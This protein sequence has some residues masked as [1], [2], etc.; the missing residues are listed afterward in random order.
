MSQCHSDRRLRTHTHVRTQTCEE[1]R[2]AISEVDW[3]KPANAENFY[4]SEW[5]E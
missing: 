5:K 2:K 1:G 4:W 3:K